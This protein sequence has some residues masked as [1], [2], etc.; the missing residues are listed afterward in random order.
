MLLIFWPRVWGHL[1][2][3]VSQFALFFT[4]LKNKRSISQLQPLHSVIKPAHH[5]VMWCVKSRYSPVDGAIFTNTK[6]TD[7]TGTNHLWVHT[8]TDWGFGC[9]TCSKLLYFG[10]LRLVLG[11]AWEPPSDS[12][13]ESPTV[14]S[15]PSFPPWH[16]VNRITSTSVITVNKA[17]PDVTAQVSFYTPQHRPWVHT[18]NTVALLCVDWNGRWCRGAVSEV[19]DWK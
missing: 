5:L 10:P 6:H 15:K 17:L 13:G 16:P 1:S 9:L 7:S 2:L 18:G 14:E 12:F 11:L 4:P 3:A 8:V 19:Q